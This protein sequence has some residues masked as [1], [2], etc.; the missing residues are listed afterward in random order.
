M[1]VLDLDVDE[2]FCRLLLHVVP[3][4]LFA[5]GTSA[6]S[7]NCRW[8]GERSRSAA[9]SP[10]TTPFLCARV[11]LGPPRASPTPSGLSS[12]GTLAPANGG[13]GSRQP[14]APPPVTASGDAVFAIIP[15]RHVR[16]REGFVQ[17][18]LSAMLDARRINA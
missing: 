4:G 10:A 18:V 14:L 7:A 15:V 2:F 1:K 17:L 8:A 6:R 5:S 11:H 9:T 12:P 3:D 16:E 13:R